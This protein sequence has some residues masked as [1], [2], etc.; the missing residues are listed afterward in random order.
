MRD[1]LGETLLAEGTHLFRT[2]LIEAIIC[3]HEID[4]DETAIL[5]ILISWMKQDEANIE[6]GKR[7]VAHIQLCYT[8][9]D[10]LKYVVRKCGVVAGD[11]VD[12]ALQ[13]IEE[14]LA[15]DAPDDKE[16]VQVT[17]ACACKRTSGWAR[18]RLRL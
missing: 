2:K 4:V 6:V 17:G 16:H 10:R 3:N 18:K 13:E 14:A 9:P 12:A 5:N 15:N 8:K 1:N 7:Q 11:T